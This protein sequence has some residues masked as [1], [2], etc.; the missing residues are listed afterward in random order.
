MKKKIDGIW[1][2]KNGGIWKKTIGG[3]WKRNKTIGGVQ[4]TTT[5]AFM[6]VC[7]CMCRDWRYEK[8]WLTYSQ[9]AV[10]TWKQEML[11]DLKM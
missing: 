4:A 9:Y 8:V 5:P 6:Y 11:A 7:V 1:K 3:I 10:T 2:K